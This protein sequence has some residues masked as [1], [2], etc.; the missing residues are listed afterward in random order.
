MFFSLLPSEVRI[1]IWTIANENDAKVIKMER[2]IVSWWPKPKVLVNQQED[3]NR[4]VR[5]KLLRP[6]IPVTKQEDKNELA[7][8]KDYKADR[9]HHSDHRG[10]L[11]AC[12]ESREQALKVLT[13]LENAMHFGTGQRVLVNRSIDKIYLSPFPPTICAPCD[14][15]CYV[16]QPYA[17]ISSC[18]HT[19]GRLIFADFA[20]DDYE[21]TV[22]SS[23][24]VASR[25]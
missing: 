3:R 2:R 24:P 9:T 15:Y 10:L 23:H 17:Y 4:L 5:S 19:R 7:R 18:R 20:E 25:S 14:H 22:A 8:Q 16:W 11:G 21:D 1:K 6:R 12:F 13:P